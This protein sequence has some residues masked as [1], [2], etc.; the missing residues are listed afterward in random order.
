MRKNATVTDSFVVD[1]AVGEV[2]CSTTAPLVA[3]IRH[4]N[5]GID[6]GGPGSATTA[7]G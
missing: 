4:P 6:I 5:S 1:I 3:Q 2:G 7:S